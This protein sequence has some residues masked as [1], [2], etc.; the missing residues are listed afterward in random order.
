MG[1]IFQKPIINSYP[2]HLFYKP[3]I[4]NC[5][6]VQP[7]K[8][9]LILI[10]YY[11]PLPRCPMHMR[12]STALRP[13]SVCAARAIDEFRSSAIYSDR[14]KPESLPVI[15]N[16]TRRLEFQSCAVRAPASLRAGAQVFNFVK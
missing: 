11:W 10:P 16:F 4:K 9:K 8:N 6:S 5:K 12:P 3:I 2:Q 13:N 1:Q 7:P 15:R 14:R